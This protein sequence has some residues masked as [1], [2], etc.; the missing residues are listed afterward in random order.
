MPT[1]EFTT[2][3]SAEADNAGAQPEQY[4]LD[5]AGT[6][7]RAALT[8][9]LID[10]LHEVRAIRLIEAPTEE[11]EKAVATHK[12][13]A[14][15]NGTGNEPGADGPS[16][17]ERIKA[18]REARKAAIQS[19]EAHQLRIKEFTAKLGGGSSNNSR[20]L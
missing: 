16:S 19:P 1:I 15:S 10:V 3:A 4:P 2:D 17:F 20:K 7:K 5:L 14:D 12:L 13:A 11:F 6:V 18:E 9:Q 8:V